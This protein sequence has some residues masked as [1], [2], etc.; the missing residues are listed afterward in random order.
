MVNSSSILCVKETRK[1]K[2]RMELCQQS[3]EDEVEKG[4]F[5]YLPCSQKASGRVLCSKV[6]TPSRMPSSVYMLDEEFTYGI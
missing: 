3:V 5:F 1:E 4:K 6:Q 2:T